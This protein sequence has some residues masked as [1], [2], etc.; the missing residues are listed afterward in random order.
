[1]GV[2]ANVAKQNRI[3]DLIFPSLHRNHSFK[4]PEAMDPWEIIE[5][6]A[7]RKRAVVFHF[8]H[9]GTH[10]HVP[11]CQNNTIGIGREWRTHATKCLCGQ[12]GGDARYSVLHFA[13]GAPAATSAASGGD[14]AV[15]SRCSL[16]RRTISTTPRQQ[17]WQPPGSQPTVWSGRGPPA[18]GQVDSSASP[19]G[20]A[21]ICL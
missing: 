10:S 8:W 18:S 6:R 4:W 2:V 20:R 14:D 1:M 12:S 9:D 17:V 21:I 16:Y 5:T 11:S 3:G 7:D 13:C 19:S 15:S